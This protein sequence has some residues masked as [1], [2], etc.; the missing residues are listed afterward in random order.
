MR[1]IQ[2]LTDFQVSF[3]QRQMKESQDFRVR[4]RSH[5]LLLS[6]KK[7]SIDQLA[8]IFS[9]NRETIR[10]W[11][12]RWEGAQSLEDGPRSGRP[13]LVSGEVEKKT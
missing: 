11:F 8:D 7:Y 2:K 9:V 1:Y 4:Q 13:N 10:N 3:L 12:A 6:H 5:A